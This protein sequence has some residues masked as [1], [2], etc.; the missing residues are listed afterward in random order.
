MGI[1]AA[2]LGIVVGYREIRRLAHLAGRAGAMR[3]LL[4]AGIVDAQDAL[5][6]DWYTRWC[7][8]P[9]SK[10]A[11]TSSQPSYRGWHPCL[12]RATSR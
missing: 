11:P 8:Q 3:I 12:T 4:T 1:T 6:M 5:H 10:N 2:R 9:K 7:R